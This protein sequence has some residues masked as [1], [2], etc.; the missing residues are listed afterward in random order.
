MTAAKLSDDHVPPEIVSSIFYTASVSDAMA[1]LVAET[2]GRTQRFTWGNHGAIQLLGYGLE[3][4]RAMPV[5]QLFPHLGGGELKLLLRRERAA[6]R[7]L[8]GPERTPPRT[9]SA[10]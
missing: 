3:D 6:R 8:G 4:L 9:T 5:E 10:Q 1:L 2:Q 7:T